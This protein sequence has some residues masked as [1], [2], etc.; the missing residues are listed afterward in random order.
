[1]ETS[2]LTLG[3]GELDPGKVSWEPAGADSG[4]CRHSGTV[5][6]LLGGPGAARAAGHGSQG[7]LGQGQQSWGPGSASSVRCGRWQC[8][9]L[10]LAAAPCRYEGISR[11][12]KQPPA[13]GPD[14]VPWAVHVGGME[15]L[16]TPNSGKEKILER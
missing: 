11:I 16:G 13:R 12:V 9:V 15:A 3:S 10:V 2:I 4:C 6:G 1:M 14:R 5:R 8:Q 7:S